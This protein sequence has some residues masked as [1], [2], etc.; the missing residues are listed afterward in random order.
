[1]TIQTP[2]GQKPVGEYSPARDNQTVFRCSSQHR[3][4]P[5]EEI[6]KLKLALRSATGI[7]NY[8]ARG[9]W[10]QS[11]L[12]YTIKRRLDFDEYIYRFA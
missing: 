4:P 6:W 7:L 12:L 3:K 11:F 8:G 1:M 9:S 5:K 10:A 2:D